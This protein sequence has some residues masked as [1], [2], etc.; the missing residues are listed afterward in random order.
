LSPIDKTELTKKIK[1]LTALTA[2]ERSALLEL[3]NTRKKYG[4]V[5]EDK[6]EKVEDDLRTKFPILTEVPGRRI[7]GTGNNPPNH[8]LIEGDNLHALTALQYTHQGKVDVIYIDPP[9]NTGNKDFVYNDHFVDKEDQWRHS[10]WLS[11]MEKRLKLA[12]SLLKETGSIFISIDDNEQ[13]QVKMLCDEIFGQGNFVASVVW[14]KKR[15]KDNS[16]KFFSGTH[17]YLLSYC[18]NSTLFRVRKLEM[19]PETLKA[20]RNA[21]SDERGSYRLLGLWARQQGGSLFAY[22][23]SN[24]E[25]FPEQLWLVSKS[26]ME[27]LD[28]DRRLVSTGKRLYRKLFLTETNGSIPETVWLDSSNN[29]NAKDEIKSILGSAEFDTPKPIPF[30][31]K[32][33]KIAGGN[34]SVILDFFAGSGTTLHAT[35]A[36]N[37]EDGGNR[38][39]ILVTNN[40]NKICEEVTYE[41][42]RRVIKGYSNAKGVD[43]PGLTA[44]S[45]RYYQTGFVDRE[46]SQ[47]NRR[48]L[49]KASVDLLCL[50]ENSYA[51]RL[52]LVVDDRRVFENHE[53]FLFVLFDPEVIPDT[54]EVIKA[55]TKPCKVYVFAPGPY[56][57]DDDFEEVID[58]VT[59]CALP[60]ALIQAFQKVMPP[61]GKVVRDDDSVEEGAE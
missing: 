40:E 47:T 33:L 34:E 25:S 21:D 9:Y 23:T 24:N 52:D 37:A 15:G 59:L 41:R 26:T 60:E 56:A 20:Y 58:K 3:L 57:W 7:V 61:E 12:K 31:L 48:A 14:H 54:V 49:T 38:Q 11:F 4:L 39:C 17:E 30:I 8:V 44:N 50:K 45:L 32:I 6:P 29:A 2:D 19:G 36:L 28:R 16:A 22:K 55:Q 53:C 27:E 1:G 43:V 46:R 5:W 18:I 10:K 35:M 51:E 42:N 13:A